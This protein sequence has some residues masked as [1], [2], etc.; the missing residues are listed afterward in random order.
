MQIVDCYILE[1]PFKNSQISLNNS[2]L[3]KFQGEEIDNCWGK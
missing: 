2:Y 3:E 1:K